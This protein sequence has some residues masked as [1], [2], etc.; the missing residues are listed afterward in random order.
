M[1]PV[2]LDQTLSMIVPMKGVENILI[3]ND[4]ERD[5]TPENRLR[6]I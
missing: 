5:E 3:V 2:A 6:K 4:R 1:S